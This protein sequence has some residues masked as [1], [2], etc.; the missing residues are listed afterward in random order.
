MQLKITWLD[1]DL[2]FMRKQK[3]LSA[4]FD[5]FMPTTIKNK[6]TNK[7]THGDIDISLMIQI[8]DYD[9]EGNRKMSH[10]AIYSSGRT[11][12]LLTAT[13]QPVFDKIT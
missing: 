13:N 5:F 2:T 10:S 1:P 7:E 8:F 4:T 6:Q 9:G 12:F 11:W 3:A